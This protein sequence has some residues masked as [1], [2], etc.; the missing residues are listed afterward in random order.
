MRPTPERMRAGIAM[1]LLLGLALGLRLYYFTG[2]ALGDDIMYTSQVLA[3]AYANGWPPEPYHWHTRLGLTMPTVLT[4]KLLGPIPIAFVLL[5]L[6][7]SLIK[8]VVSFGIAFRY[9]DLRGA[10]LVGLLMAVFPSEV[11][12]ATHLFPDALVGLFSTLSV[13][14]WLRALQ[15]D[16]GIDYLLAGLWFAAG[17]LCRETVLHEGMVYI[18]LWL[19]AGKWKRPRL[20]LVAVAPVAVVLLEMMLYGATTSD[21][22]YRWHAILDVQSTI[23]ESDPSLYSSKLGGNFWTGPILMAIGSF[24]LGLLVALA[25]PLAGWA[26]FRS[27]SLRPIAVWLLVGFGWF[28]YGTT[29]PS[30]WVPLHRD[31]RYAM[32]FSLPIVLLVGGWLRTGPR[33]L[34]WP[35][36]AGLIG[37]CMICP[38]LDLGNSVL[39]PHEKFLAAPHKELISLEPAEYLAARWSQGFI[40]TPEF[41]LLSDSGRESTARLLVCLS[42]SKPRQ[43]TEARHILYCPER[44]PVLHRQLQAAG[45]SEVA[46]FTGMPKPLRAFLGMLLAPAVGPGERVE[47]LMHPPG[48]RL[49]ARPGDKA[50]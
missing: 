1:L 29:I 42:G 46:T 8:V 15:S 45:W 47:R 5:P 25:L 13:W 21:P 31:A 41:S 44:S 12:Y 30:G 7:A 37:I 4:V 38:G 32:A 19:W 16:R 3:H 22:L 33:L 27:Q 10:C 17:Y 20:P 36:A 6:L 24:E 9:T 39:T 40:K 48:L 26:L 49:V 11:I 14:F 50:E 18:A 43:A 35:I 28:F 34:V 23:A 2:L